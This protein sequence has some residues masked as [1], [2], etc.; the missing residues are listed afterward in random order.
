[1]KYFLIIL[2]LLLCTGC[3]TTKNFY[4]QYNKYDVIMQNSLLF[5]QLTLN[6]KSSLFLI[7]TGSSKSFLDINKI[8]KYKFGYINKPIEKY[9]GIGGLQSIYTVY[10]YKIT[11][12]HI[13]FLG[14]N[15]EELN[16]YFKKD[17]LTIVG[18]I[19]SDYLVFRN[20]IIDYENSKLYLKK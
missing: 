15:L 9:V 20:A 11:E 7:D 2:L 5:I 14:I 19:G 18:L 10:E 1:M 16:P 17:N 3:I 6:N 8:E 4:S 12:M 13:P